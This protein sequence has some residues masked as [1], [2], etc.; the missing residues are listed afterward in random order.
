[1]RGKNTTG[2]N[3]ASKK[4]DLAGPQESISKQ[5]STRPG[6]LHQTEGH[7]PGF[8]IWAAP[9]KKMHQTSPELPS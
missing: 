6:L 8:I 3:F 9:M 1:M 2:F 4:S 7:E 5:E